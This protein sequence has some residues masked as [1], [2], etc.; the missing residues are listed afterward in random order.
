[1][2]KN[3]IKKEN[4]IHEKEQSLEVIYNYNDSTETSRTLQAREIVNE[5]DEVGE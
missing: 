3:R 4:Q 5:N 2:R 1:M